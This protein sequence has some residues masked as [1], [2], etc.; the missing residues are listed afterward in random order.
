MLSSIPK[1]MRALGYSAAQIVQNFLGYVPAPVIYGFVVEITGGNGSRYGMILLM[2]WSLFGVFFLYL[3]KNSR[4]QKHADYMKQQYSNKPDLDFSKPDL[5]EPKPIEIPDKENFD[6]KV[7]IN[8]ESPKGKHSRKYT[9]GDMA[10]DMLGRRKSIVV[11]ST[12]GNIGKAP[13]IEKELETLNQAFVDY[14]TLRKSRKGTFMSTD[15]LNNVNMMFGRGSIDQIRN[16]IRD[17][18]L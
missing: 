17:E 4:L 15:R 2:S 6:V 3:A 16:D 18:M 11:I 8:A 1:K 9:F 13:K 12:I 5:F 10:L 7:D 14:K